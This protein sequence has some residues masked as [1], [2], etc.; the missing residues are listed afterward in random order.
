MYQIDVFND[1]VRK[2]SFEFRI[3][4]KVKMSLVFQYGSNTSVHR[5]NS[6]KRL[7][8]AARVVGPAYTQDKYDLDFTV[9][10]KTNNCA[11]ADIVPKGNTQIWGVVYE[12]PDNLIYRHSS[13]TKKSLD[14]IEGEGGNYE[15]VQIQVIS[16]GNTIPVL[17]YVVRKR[18][19]GLA[20][21]AKYA[22]II[23]NGLKSHDIPEEY[24]EY[25]YNRIL[26]NNRALQ[27]EL[28]SIA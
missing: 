15:R 1:V 26:F 21:S 28:P 22:S 16:N 24:L 2:Y 18:E 6:A 23:I 11:A 5:L 10:S 12:I 13:G 25:V 7:D 3:K 8:G 27:S 4:E 17:T 19:V 14:A 20:T 9:W